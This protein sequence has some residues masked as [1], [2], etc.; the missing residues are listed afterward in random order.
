MGKTRDAEENKGLLFV[1]SRLS[2]T[3][4]AD[5]KKGKELS[6]KLLSCC[7]EMPCWETLGS[8]IFLDINF[9]CTTQLKIVP[10]HALPHGI[11]TP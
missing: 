10:G 9:M 7:S 4:D 11:G 3:D 2:G 5:W 1:L 6:T 8:G